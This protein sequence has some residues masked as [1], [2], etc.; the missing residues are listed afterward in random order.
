MLEAFVFPDTNLF[1]HYKSLEEIDWLGLLKTEN[2][3]IVVT[4]VL[5]R[6]LNRK[7]EL[8]ETKKIRKRADSALKRLKSFSRQPA[9]A[10]VKDRVGLRFRHNEAL[11]DFRSHRLDER[12]SDD[13][14]I[15]TMLEFRTELPDARIV[16]ATSDIGLQLKG[17]GHGLEF[18]EVPDAYLLPEE[19][20][21]DE[22]RIQELTKELA[23]YKTR[24]PDLKLTF[25]NDKEFVRIRF[26]RVPF[27]SAEEIARIMADVRIA[28]PKAAKPEGYSGADLMRGGISPGDIDRF[29]RRMDDFYTAFEKYLKTYTEFDD[30]QRRSFQLGIILVNSGS[31]KAEDIDIDLHF[32]DGMLVLSEDDAESLQTPPD[33]PKAPEGPTSWMQEQTLG[34]ATFG[35]IL[36]RANPGLS[37]LAAINRNLETIGQNVSPPE[38]RRTKSFEVH[39]HVRSLKH[40]LHEE[41]SPL[42]VKFDSWE[43]AKPFEIEYKLLAANVPQPVHAKLHAIPEIVDETT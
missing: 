24:T 42:F 9:P 1:L 6:E 3:V 34:A 36:S 5:I 21:P 38:I 11:I 37:S 13:C 26:G 33:E 2:A 19:S 22:K 16:L 15:A 39:F 8:G 7:K 32:P 29:N 40:H 10:Q 12:I 23:T 41:L 17:T 4:Q 43:T 25:D 31:A 35:S 28:H 20:D 18:L 14:L 30:A 27:M